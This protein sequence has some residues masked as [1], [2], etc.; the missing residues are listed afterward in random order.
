LNLNILPLQPEDIN[1]ILKWNSDKGKDFLVQWAGS[2]YIHPLTYEQIKN[3]LAPQDDYDECWIYKILL[4]DE[5][6]EKL[7]GTA[8]LNTAGMPRH[9]A[10][11]CRYLIAPDYQNRG[12]GCLS[13]ILLS[14]KAYKDLGFKALRLRVF[15]YNT[16]A[17][18]CYEKAGFSIIE[19][20]TWENN[21]DIYEM[22]LIL[23]KRRVRM[24]PHRVY[25]RRA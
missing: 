14:E 15:T 5:T 1:E 18:R 19:Q 24:H 23:S 25:Q 17:V 6:G 2:G 16:R 8:E 4:I 20:S 10:M 21:L 22:E 13:L 7:I 3:R 11:L 9:T 12:Y